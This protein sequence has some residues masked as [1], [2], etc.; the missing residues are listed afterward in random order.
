MRDELD[1]ERD[2]RRSKRGKIEE[3]GEDEVGDADK[4]D[5]EPGAKAVPPDASRPL[6]GLCGAHRGAAFKEDRCLII[7]D[8]GA[9]Q[10]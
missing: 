3:G 6:P 9:N 1:A 8:R 4:R 2:N 10:D 5:E 7:V